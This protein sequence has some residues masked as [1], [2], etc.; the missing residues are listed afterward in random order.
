MP[1]KPGCAVRAVFLKEIIFPVLIFYKQR[2]PEK[3]WLDKMKQRK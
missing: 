3:S 1:A 2:W